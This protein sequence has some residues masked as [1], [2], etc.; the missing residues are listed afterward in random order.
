MKVM[1]DENTELTGSFIALVNA[2]SKKDA[3]EM[4]RRRAYV[5]VGVVANKTTIDKYK[6]KIKKT[7]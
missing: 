4:V 1:L 2:Q 7:V 6:E 5:K 3:K